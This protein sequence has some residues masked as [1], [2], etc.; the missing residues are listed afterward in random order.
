MKIAL[1]DLGPNPFKKFINEGKLDKEKI[2]LLK[3]SINKDGFWDN[4]LCRKKNDKYELA[5]GHHRIEAAKQI[6]GEN[7][8]ADIPCK[9]LSDE[10][11]LRILGNENTVAN[12]SLTIYQID[13]VK[14]TQK[15]LAEHPQISS[16]WKS[17]QDK[18]HGQ[19]PDDAVS[20]SKFLGEKNWSKSKVAD[21]LRLAQKLHPKILKDLRNVADSG[22]EYSGLSVSHGIEISRLPEHKDQLQ[23]YKIAKKH[24]LSKEQTKAVVSKIKAENEIKVPEIKKAAKQKTIE[25][26]LSDL[27]KKLTELRGILKAVL[28]YRRDIKKGMRILLDSCLSEFK[29]TIDEYF[30]D[31]D[32]QIMEHAAK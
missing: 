5:Y 22:G 7:Y 1:K 6:L 17:G 20:I 25:D 13:Q 4:V 26:V 21:L 15:F 16:G 8:E 23:A 2:E 14:I 32:M 31:E 28:P 11:M 18:G 10:S 27:V 19:K 9:D 24:D 3:E 12:Q 29:K 30:K